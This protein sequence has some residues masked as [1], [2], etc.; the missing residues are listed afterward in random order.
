MADILRTPYTGSFQENLEIIEYLCGDLEF[1]PEVGLAADI[2]EGKAWPNAVHD[3]NYDQ[4]RVKG[5]HWYSYIYYAFNKRDSQFIILPYSNGSGEN[6]K[7][8]FVAYEYGIGNALVKTGAMMKIKPADIAQNFMIE[9]ITPLATGAQANACCWYFGF[10]PSRWTVRG[11]QTITMKN[12][13]ETIKAMKTKEE[14]DKHIKVMFSELYFVYKPTSMHLYQYSFRDM[15]DKAKQA[16]AYSLAESSIW[17]KL[18]GT[19]KAEVETQC[20]EYIRAVGNAEQ[21]NANTVVD[22][23]TISNADRN[24]FKVGCAKSLCNIIAILDPKKENVL[25][26]ELDGNSVMDKAMMNSIIKM[27]EGNP[28]VQT[29]SNA[30]RNVFKVGC[31]KS[32]CNIIAILDP[33]KEKEDVLITEEREQLLKKLDGNSVIDKAMMNSIIKMTEGNP[34]VHNVVG[35]FNWIA[36]EIAPNHEILEAIL[37]V[38]VDVTKIITKILHSIP[39]AGSVLAL[40]TTQVTKLFGHFLR[41]MASVEEWK[42]NAAKLCMVDLDMK[43][44]DWNPEY[45]ASSDKNP[46]TVVARRRRRR[47]TTNRR[48]RGDTDGQVWT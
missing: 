7:T 43:G 2:A 20:A 27:T 15:I 44:C 48:N 13:K 32:L 39:F 8:I 37:G 3:L 12:L 28:L 21:K 5:Q 22:G 33:K 18:A 16:Y 29:I 14:K 23:G 26:S 35:T 17:Q 46:S 40:G 34:L 11:Y 36:S 1:K 30:D 10:T 25:L 38:D 31:A 45:E 47:R 4:V 24:V 19:T 42:D 9:N 41:P 6:K